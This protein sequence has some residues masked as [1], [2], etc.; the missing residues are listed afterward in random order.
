[1]PAKPLRNF[2]SYAAMEALNIV[3]VPCAVLLLAPPSSWAEIL[4]MGLA[5]ASCAGFLLVG[6]AYWAGLDQRLTRSNRSALTKA[7]ALADR[8]EIPLLLITG[9]ALPMLAFAIHKGGWSWSVTGAAILTLLAALE[10]VNYYHRQLQHFDRS[11]DFKRLMTGGGFRRSH[12]ARD[13]AA[14]RRER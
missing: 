9:A 14:Y 12:M 5:M 2:R 8:L 6:A 3:L 11:S 7:L 1:V 13:L 4:A 10:Y